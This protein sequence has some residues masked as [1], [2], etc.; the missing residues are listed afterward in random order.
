[1]PIRW[2]INPRLIILFIIS[3]ASLLIFYLAEDKDAF[4]NFFFLPTLF[5]GYVYSCRGGVI[6][7]LISI[8][9]V[10]VIAFMS[11]ENY[12]TFVTHKVFVWG[13][14]LIV[15]GFMMGKLTDQ[16]NATY[17]GTIATLAL[18]MESR[19]PYTYGHSARVAEV[20][21]RIAKKLSLPKHEQNIIRTAGLLHDIGK[22]GVRED[23]LRKRGPLNKEEY[24]H[25]GQHVLIGASILSPV[26]LLKDVI[27]FIYY[28]HEH[29][30]GNGY[31]HKKG[32]DIPLGARILAVAD[33]Y[34]A[35]TTDRPYRK[36][37]PREKI[38]EIFDAESNKQFDRRI[39]EAL[40]QITDNLRLD[41]HPS[42]ED[43]IRNNAAFKG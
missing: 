9:F 24:D 6:T 5:A 18:A 36:A 26:R 21:V 20:A 33:A 41:I 39:V 10:I 28:H 37:L 12:W 34:D 19:D 35:M 25:I 13:C 7:A 17:L 22:F 23:I 11:F 8:L 40:Y 14:F 1:M 29:I 16:I 31:L 15:A 3:I 30:D 27:P 2:K 38:R 32:T 42:A 43:D 4:I